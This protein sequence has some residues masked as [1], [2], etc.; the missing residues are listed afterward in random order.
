MIKVYFILASLAIIIP[1]SY[2]FISDSKIG[3][4]KVTIAILLAIIIIILYFISSYITYILEDQKVFMRMYDEFPDIK[5]STG[6]GTRVNNDD[7]SIRYINFMFPP[8]NAIITP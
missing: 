6:F 7:G 2:G 4:K 1:I 8:E 3:N 5:N